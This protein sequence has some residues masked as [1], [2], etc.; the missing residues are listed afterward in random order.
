MLRLSL[1]ALLVAS[2][3]VA[4][5]RCVSISVPQGAIAERHGSWAILSN[6][7]WQFLRGVFVLNPQTSAGLP[8]G[9]RVALAT[10]PGQKGGLIFFID[11]KRACDPMPVP[12]ELLDMLAAVKAKKISHE[13]AT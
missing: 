4:A 2:P 6:D 8:Y 11:G 10:I 1:V 13:G 7:E 9:D 5:E 12:A 3:A